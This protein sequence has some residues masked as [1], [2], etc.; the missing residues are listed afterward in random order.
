M[1]RSSSANAPTS[2]RVTPIVTM[3]IPLVTGLDEI[4]RIAVRTKK[5]HL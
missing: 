1:F 5:I 3:E 2:T 4:P